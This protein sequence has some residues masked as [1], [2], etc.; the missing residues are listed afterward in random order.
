[1]E[2]MLMVEL[3]RGLGLVEDR[4]G[5]VGDRRGLVEDRRGLVEDRR[6]HGLFRTSGK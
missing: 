2:P 5:L 4:R 6:V 1:M 3:R